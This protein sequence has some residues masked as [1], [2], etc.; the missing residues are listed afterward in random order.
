MA[1]KQGMNRGFT[2]RSLVVSLTAMLAMGIWIEYVER[3]GRY[4][5]PL[6][7]NVPPNAA[8]GI[9]LVVMGVSALLYFL[10]RSLRLA[11]AELLVVYAA[12]VLA[13]PLMTQGLWGRFFGLLAA[14]PHNQDFKSYESLPSMLWPHGPNLVENG[15]FTKGLEGFVL[16]GAGGETWTNID[17]RAKGIWRSPVLDNAG[18]TGSVSALTFAI[19]RFDGRGREVLVP[20]EHFLFS[21][22][23]RVSGIQKS[24]AY[25]VE[26]RADTGAAHKIFMSAGA[27]QPTFANPCG[28]MRVG[29]S[30]IAIPVELR[31]NLAFRI[32]LE[33]PGALA[34]QDLEFMSVEAI[35][36]LYAGRA[37]V[38]ESNLAKLGP[39]ERG[40]L[41]VMPDNLFSLKGLKFLVTGYI[42]LGQWVQPALVWLVLFGGLF[43]GFL[44]LNILLRKQWAEN[45]R[46]AFPQTILPRLLFAEAEGG[47]GG[48]HYVFLRRRAM[49][50]G[51]FLT[52]P[53]VLLR[54]LHFYNPS[55]PAP[56]IE[57]LQFANYFI[58]PLAK[59]FL[60]DVSMDLGWIGAGF[61]FSLLAIAL[62][63]DT[64]VLFSL[65]ASFFLFQLW[66]L[67]GKA[68][69]WTRFPGYPWKFQQHMG[70]FI[71]YALLALFVAR[72]HLAQVFR[73][74]FSAGPAAGNGPG[75][76]RGVY[77]LALTMVAVSLGVM[78]AWGVW[79]GMGLAASLLFFS[80]ML[81]V[82]FA[83][84]K[85]RA[86]CGAPY[87]YIT[88]Y[89]GMQFVA[90]IGGF[91]VFGSSGMLVAT[92][93]SGFM[94]TASFLL[95]A[96]TQVEMMELG[97]QM[98]VRQRDVWAGLSLGLLGA[99]FIGGF[100]LLC[101]AY[102]FGANRLE[103]TWPYEQNNYFSAFRNGEAGADRAFENQTLFSTPEMRPLDL[104]HNLD[105]KGLGIG[106]AITWLLAGLRSV[107]MWFPLHPI[108]Y[109]LAPS[110]FMGGFWFC[111]F[112]AWLI[113][114]LVLRL[115]GARSI[116][117]GLVPF[118]VGMFLA[119]VVSILFF[120]LVGIVLRAQGVTSVYSAIP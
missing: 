45:E 117:E 4:G 2:L 25:F 65:W 5:G 81:V 38:R 101:W 95:M 61:T 15:R 51:F 94:T 19:R 44:G 47:Q 98:N 109:V 92:I 102:G 7:E 3:Y 69:N 53:L 71:G 70:A 13:A 96:P 31:S 66:N 30:P 39:G 79:T 119:C 11:P 99:L 116:R 118:C 22:L 105:A 33:G 78:A 74:V 54:G 82:G 77:R 1:S 23:V 6:G 84:S 21:M 41:V 34:L 75:E 115:G 62:L 67:F 88:P 85:I 113:R 86:E 55:I 42:P 83:A 24:T 68:F 46:F 12:L 29:A 32:G 80:Y 59:A 108:G 37:L 91:A 35:E 89:F 100:V 97:R 17:R 26:M 49:W 50:L 107:F 56:L 14:I 93:A 27:T 111:A 104:R 63:I 10:R 58:N 110:Y 52:L 20:G 87:S 40:S 18:D 72:R 73:L 120:D 76:S 90:A 28:F 43:V 106:L 36:G 9:I 60:Q 114:V 103:T 48:V 16:E 64:N 57:N 8:V 112:A